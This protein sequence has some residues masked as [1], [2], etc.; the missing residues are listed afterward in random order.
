MR[1]SPR[2][3][4]GWVSGFRRERLD[5]VERP[6][7]WAEY[8]GGRLVATTRA[9]WTLPE[10][11]EPT[12]VFWDEIDRAVW[13]DGRLDVHV[14]VGGRQ[15]AYVLTDPDGLPEAVRERVTS[16]IVVN[17]THRLAAGGGVRIV[18]RRRGGES[19]LRWAVVYDR[20]QDVDD[21]RAREEAERRLAEAREAVGE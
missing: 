3:A 8:A 2:R 10:A 17:T 19:A 13:R 4:P 12:S 6:L 14:L 16:S 21:P 11:G 9:L 1:L 15:A 5:A 7:A 18:A 20:E